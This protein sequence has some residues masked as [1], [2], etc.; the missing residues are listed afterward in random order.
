LAPRWLLNYISVA[1]AFTPVQ[2]FIE[3]VV[4]ALLRSSPPAVIRGGK[5]SVR[6]PLLKKLLP[7]QTFDRMVSKVFGLDRFTP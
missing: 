3:P 1:T 6:L 5:N 7:L 4:D 2:E